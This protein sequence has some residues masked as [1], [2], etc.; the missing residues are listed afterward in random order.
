M[1]A[2][3][4]STYKICV[5]MGAQYRNLRKKQVRK[6]GAVMGLAL[7]AFMPLQAAQAKQ[8]LTYEVYAG[9]INAVSATMTIDAAKTGQYNVDMKAQTKG[10]LAKLAPWS[11]TFATKGWAGKKDEFRPQ[12]HKSTAIWRGEEDFKEYYYNKDGTF[13]KL[14]KKDPD[15]AAPIVE[16]IDSE[17]VNQ[18]TDVLSATLEV[19][20][21]VAQGQECKGSSEVFDGKRRFAMHFKPMGV[22]QLKASNYNSY[23]GPA[24][25]CVVEVEPVAGAWHS[26]PRGWLSIQEQGRG[27]GTLPT[28]WMATIE[29]GAP[30]V[31]VKVQIKTDYGVLFM[32]LV[33]YKG[34]GPLKEAKKNDKKAGAVKL[35]EQDESVQTEILKMAEN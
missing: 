26:K 13:D 27:K 17:L 31:P 14:V 20:A 21:R 19:M 7:M 18:T 12:L 10:F 5:D 25:R 1:R 24:A 32:H 4:L 29:E 11:G 23:E 35:S 28:V 15:D 34:A 30:A 3:K 33:D 8:E 6:W 16:K 9:G 2:L 22:E